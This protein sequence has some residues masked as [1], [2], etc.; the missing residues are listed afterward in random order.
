MSH[1]ILVCPSRREGAAILSLNTPLVKLTYCGIH[2][3][4]AFTPPWD[5]SQS[6]L[7]IKRYADRAVVR[8][9]HVRMNIGINYFALDTL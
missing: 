6:H 8:S 4:L 5:N 7:Y 1:N 9:K 2:L 3:A